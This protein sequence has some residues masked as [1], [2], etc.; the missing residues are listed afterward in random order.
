M[1]GKYWVTSSLVHAPKLSL[2]T[3]PLMSCTMMDLLPTFVMIPIPL[4]SVDGAR[5]L[6]SSLKLNYL[7]LTNAEPS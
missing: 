4:C 7:V 6:K 2:N 5:Q 1:A 3:F